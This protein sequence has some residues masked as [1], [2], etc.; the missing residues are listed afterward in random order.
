MWNGIANYFFGSA[1][2]EEDNLLDILENF[3]EVE[4]FEDVEF[5][6]RPAEEDEWFLVERSESTLVPVETLTSPVAENEVEVHPVFERASIIRRGS[7]LIGDPSTAHHGPIPIQAA[8]RFPLAQP[9]KDRWLR[10]RKLNHKALEHSNKVYQH[11][12][13]CKRQRR[14]NYKLCYSSK[15]ERKC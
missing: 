13:K 3:D 8:N 12:S 9:P 10:G 6:I 11:Q 2:V 14:Y 1:S 7:R 15:N 4:K 5:T